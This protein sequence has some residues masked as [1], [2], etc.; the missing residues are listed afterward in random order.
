MFGI[1]IPNK[2]N[3]E[4]NLRKKAAKFFYIKNSFISIKLFHF[5]PISFLIL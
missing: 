2:K 3:N 1:D 4:E 5:I